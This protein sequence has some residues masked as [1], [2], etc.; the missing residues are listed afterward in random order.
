MAASPTT[1][2]TDPEAAASGLLIYDGDCGFCT[3]AARRFGD[4][5]HGSASVQPWQALEL[6]DYG[7]TEAQANSAVYWVADGTAHAGADAVAHSLQALA[8]PW[9]LVGRVLATPP[10]IWIGRLIYPVVARNR[11]RLPGATEACRLD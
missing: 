9:R 11:H 7:L 5:A 3:A 4:L 1:A 10:F 6:G 8:L 2:E